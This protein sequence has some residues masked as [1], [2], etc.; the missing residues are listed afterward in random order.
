MSAYI[1]FKLLL[2]SACLNKGLRDF[3]GKMCS[4]CTSVHVGISARIQGSHMGCSG[5]QG[6][7]RSRLRLWRIPRLT[8]PNIHNSTP[9]VGAGVPGPGLGLGS[10]RRRGDW[11]VSIIDRI[12]KLR[13]LMKAGKRRESWIYS[14][15]HTWK[16]HATHTCIAK[17][18]SHGTEKTEKTQQII[19][20]KTSQ[21]WLLH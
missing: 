9:V 4:F 7:C 17:L 1:T 5:L 2:I 18:T 16:R 20:T 15:P 10:A 6:L 3:F 11:L 14:H 21:C 19:W 13:W 8:E 12:M